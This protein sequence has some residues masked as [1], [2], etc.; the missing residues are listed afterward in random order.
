D[1]VGCRRHRCRIS[2]AAR[3]QGSESVQQRWRDER[4]GGERGS[5]TEGRGPPPST[6][7]SLRRG[8]EGRTRLAGDPIEDGLLHIRDALVAQP[9]QPVL[10]V[11]ASLTSFTAPR[12]RERTRERRLRTAAWLTPSCAAA[13]S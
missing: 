8:G 4:A 7:M 10:L 12:S 3:R 9:R 13:A 6:T 11:H 1:T 2:R 5:H